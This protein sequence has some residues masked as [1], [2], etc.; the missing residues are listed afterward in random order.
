MCDAQDL[1]R[2]FA[3][4][5]Q[6]GAHNINLVTP[7][8]HIATI[9]EALSIAKSEGFPL[10]F[11]Y[12]TN[13]YERVESLRILEGLVDI[14]LPDLKY[15]SSYLSERY[16]GAADYFLFA[17]PAIEEMFRQVGTLQLDDSGLAQ[18][19]LLI[20]HLVLPGSV[21]ETRRVLDHIHTAL[22]LETH[23]ALMRQYTPAHRADFAPLN[24]P[25]TARE[26]ERSL[27]YCMQLGFENVL[28]QGQSAVDASYTPPFSDH[29]E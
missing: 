6:Q 21:D 20:R 28:I 25:L 10:P 3:K 13:A 19:G 17:A 23:I 27:A 8:P 7:T 2:L 16:S 29:L 4:L 12:N 26:Y 15:V 1:C 11:V 14:Y 9:R 22:P 24:R 18:K 5:E